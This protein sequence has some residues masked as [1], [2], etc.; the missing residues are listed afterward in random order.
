MKLLA[1]QMR[2]IGVLLL[3]GAVLSACADIP[4]DSAGLKLALEQPLLLLG[5]MYVGALIS[6][7][8]T[9]STA[10]WDGSAITYATYFQRWETIVAAVLSVPIAWAGLLL[11]DQLNFAA[12]AAFGAVANTVMDVAPGKRSALLAAKSPDG[13]SKP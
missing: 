12:A 11:L 9:V 3:V 5:V 10:K 2:V 1:S 7:L 4:R 8:K 13:G 6:A